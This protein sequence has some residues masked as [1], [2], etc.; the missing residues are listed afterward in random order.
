MLIKH[1]C[2]HHYQKKF[3]VAVYGNDIWLTSANSLRESQLLNVLVLKSRWSNICCQGP[4][5]ILGVSEPKS[6]GCLEEWHK[7]Q[8]PRKYPWQSTISE[9]GGG[10]GGEYG[11]PGP[12]F[13][14]GPGCQNLAFQLGGSLHKVLWRSLPFKFKMRDQV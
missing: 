4:D 2:K 5:E 6:F 1:R 9:K 7:S 14:G 3:L 13:V 11:L 12:A 10:R 8:F